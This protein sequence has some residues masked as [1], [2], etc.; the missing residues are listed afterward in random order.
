MRIAYTGR[1]FI[2]DLASQISI[3]IAL[4]SAKATMADVYFAFWMGCMLHQF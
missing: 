4:W 2:R 3:S 1:Y